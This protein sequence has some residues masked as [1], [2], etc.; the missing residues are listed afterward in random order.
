[1]ATVVRNLTDTINLS[2]VFSGASNH[3]TENLEDIIVMSDIFSEEHTLRFSKNITDNL[4]L[5]DIFVTLINYS[6]T[7]NI[8]DT[9]YITDLLTTNVR[10]APILSIVDTILLSDTIESSANDR[11][12]KS[13]EDTITLIDIFIKTQTERYSSGVI[14]NL[15]LTD[16]FTIQYGIIVTGGL[17]D[18]VTSKSFNVGEIVTLNAIIPINKIFFKWNFNKLSINNIYDPNSNITIPQGGGVIT[19]EFVN[20]VATEDNL[21]SLDPFD[22]EYVDNASNVND[23]IITNE[24]ITPIGEVMGVA[25]H[26]YILEQGSQF[27]QIVVYKDSDSNPIDLTGYT[28]AMQVRAY[29]ESDTV[30]LLL[31]TSNGR[32]I[33]GGTNGTITLN[34]SGSVTDDLDFKW[35]YYDIELYP[36]G[37]EDNTIRV[38]Q[39]RIELNKQV[40]R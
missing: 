29:K 10:T 30:I 5:L 15:S 14:E 20:L 35:G 7:N 28:A 39:G 34:I 16:Q 25:K 33:L 27:F 12:I 4:S 32:I 23:E 36:A 11:F 31:N 1:M 21:I 19:A 6:Q 8:E 22:L 13:V 38:L 3:Y 2:D 17:I 9:V 24:T 26:D 18:G 40:T 37:N